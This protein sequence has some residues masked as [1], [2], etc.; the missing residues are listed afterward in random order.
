M[1]WQVRSVDGARHQVSLY[2]SASSELAVNVPTEKVVWGRQQM[3]SLTALRVGTSD[4]P[5]LQSSGDDIRIN[6]GYAYLAAPSVAAYSSIGSDAVLTGEFVNSG[7]LASP[8]DVRMPRAVT[9]EQPTLAFAF[10]LGSVG[11]SPVSRHVIVA[12]DEVYAIKYFGRML[13]PYWRRNGATPAVLLQAAERDYP[14][15]SA[16]CEAFDHRLMSDM[17][18][19]GGAKYAQIAALAYR[20]ALAATGIAADSYGQP[21]L[22]TKENTSN[23]DIATVDVIFP[24]D[25]VLVLLS[26]TLAKASLAADLAYA[27]SGHWRFPNAPHDLGTYP[28]VRGTDD[29]GEGMPVEESGNMIILCDAIAQDDGNARFVSPWWP[30][31]TQWAQYLEK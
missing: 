20:Q 2:D 31:I 21:L 4:Q 18:A 9:D 10:N 5:V 14:A 16:R 22:F 25:P 29:G 28:I 8:V 27:S 3:G 15:I 7:T 23:G 1:T 19:E 26:P 17:T 30:K 11:A 6:W 24:M 12:Y 13:R